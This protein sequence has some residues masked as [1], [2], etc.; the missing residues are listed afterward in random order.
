MYVCVCV[1][2]DVLTA[3]CII[4]PA[5]V[6]QWRTPKANDGTVLVTIAMNGVQYTCDDIMYTYDSRFTISPPTCQTMRLVP[7]ALAKASAIERVVFA[8]FG[9][10]STEAHREALSAILLSHG[11]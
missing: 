9:E 3:L 7:E 4:L 5:G 6:V 8:C 11:E 1:C 10:I 2:R